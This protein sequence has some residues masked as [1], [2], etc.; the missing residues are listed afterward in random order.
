M[1]GFFFYRMKLNHKTFILQHI[2]NFFYCRNSTFLLKKNHFY[3]WDFVLNINSWESQFRTTQRL[4]WS[5]SSFDLKY[6]KSQTVQSL[7]LFCCVHF[8]NIYLI[9]TILCVSVC[10]Y[11]SS[12]VRTYVSPR[13]TT[14]NIILFL[15]HYY[16]C[17]FVFHFYKNY[18]HD[19]YV[20][21]LAPTLPLCVLQNLFIKPAL[22]EVLT[23]V[24]QLEQSK[25][26]LWKY[27]AC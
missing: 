5:H 2:L 21:N 14:S 20:Y 4:I 6:S 25:I 26:L 15:L 27:M 16:T 8:M 1:Q 11:A 23:L 17:V 18:T 9:I 22:F 10:T 7:K 13:F 3:F 19:L 12:Y 24:H